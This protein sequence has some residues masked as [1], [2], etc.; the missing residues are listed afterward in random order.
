MNLSKRSFMLIAGVALLVLVALVAFLVSRGVQNSSASNLEIATVRRG[1]LM[2]TV[3]ATGS[4]SPLRQ[5][6]MAF[7][8][9]GPIT[10]LNVQQGDS[11][12]A[13]QVLAQLDTRQLDLQLV[14]AEAN[15]TAAQAKLS[16]VKSPSASDIAAAQASLASADAALAQLKTPSQNDLI[17]AKSD[18]DKAKAAVDRAQADY[19][20]IGGASNPMIGALPQ[21]VSLQQA[22]LDYQKALAA[23]NSK[24]SPT[25][26]QVK[27]ATA[28]VEQARS[29]LAK[30]TNPSPNDVQ[31]SQ[32]NVDQARA[33]RDLAK[34]Q[35]DNAIIRSPFDGIVTHV[36]FDLGSFAAA[37][38]VVL[39]V[40]DISELRIKLNIDETDIARVSPGQA[41]AITLDAYPDL[42]INAQVADV[43]STATIVQG[44]VNYVVTVALKPGEVPLK[45]GMT[46]D[47]NIVV[48]QKDNVLLVPNRAIRASNSKRL[49]TVERPGGKTEDREVKL[50]LSNDQDTEVTSGLSEGERVVIS[51]LQNNFG[52]PR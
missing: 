18:V 4:I 44:V 52:P 22:S 31:A 51:T 42:N 13:G 46:A 41:V 23:Y 20:R 26:S 14:Q 15:L 49:V 48:A 25:D 9:T 1:T 38:R 10:K 39:G 33:A 21:S 37:G 29:Q 36:D 50:G 43:A 34:A 45:I 27:Q 2:A 28:S 40:A 24:V 12:K 6:E 17:M 11:V 5:A 19:D 8:A 32:S 30:L 47:A 7:S 16:Q 3:S 35:V